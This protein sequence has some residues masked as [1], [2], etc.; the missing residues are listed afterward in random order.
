[1]KTIQLH[2]IAATAAT[3]L[4]TT[5]AGHAVLA[6]ALSNGGTQ[7]VK[8]DLATP[9]MTTLVGSIAGA[10]T[11]LQGIDFRPANGLLYGIDSAG[12]IVTVNTNTA[13][14]TLASGPIVPN[15]GTG[16]LGIDF[17]PTVDRLRLVNVNDENL[18]INVDTGVVVLPVDGTLAYAAGDPNFGV[19]PSIIEAAYTN[20]DTNPATGTQLFYIDHSLDTLV[21]TL[22]PNVGS[23]TTV[24][25]LGVPTTD[26][27]GF[28]ILSDGVGGNT[29]YAL[30]T[31]PGGS[32]GLYTI[33]LATGGAS[34]VGAINDQV[35]RPYSLAITPPAPVPE[36]GTAL[37]GLALIGTALTRRGR[38]SK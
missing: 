4:L 29:A 7:L 6:Y 16:S 9:A 8:F 28:D 31:L 19:N 20:S 15:S 26:L 27:V 38:K 10:T 21:S 32:P 37:F 17:N 12:R 33:N 22:N 25:A 35:V 11:S 13:G 5:N 14:T 36:P 2:A 30:L 23:L 3:L 18:R 1:M 34:L 24:G